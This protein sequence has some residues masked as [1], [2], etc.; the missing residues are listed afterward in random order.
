MPRRTR[1]QPDDVVQLYTFEPT[2]EPSKYWMTQ[3]FNI[4][5]PKYIHTLK[6]YDYKRKIVREKRGFLFSWMGWVALWW[7]SLSGTPNNHHRWVPKWSVVQFYL[8]FDFQWECWTRR[9]QPWV[10]EVEQVVRSVTSQSL[11]FH[12]YGVFHV[13]C[14]WWFV[15]V[16]VLFR[17]KLVSPEPVSIR[18]MSANHYSVIN[19]DY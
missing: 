1:A 10:V 8:D 2:H 18:K 14:P 5:F 19:R 16:C 6:K 15:A 17:N 7:H 4:S 3:L 12:Y 13:R 11:L 9:F